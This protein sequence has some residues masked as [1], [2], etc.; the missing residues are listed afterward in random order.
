MASPISKQDMNIMTEAIQIAYTICYCAI[1]IVFTLLLLAAEIC[2]ADVI[3]HRVCY[4]RLPTMPGRTTDTKVSSTSTST[5][6]T[7]ASDPTNNSFEA[8][9]SP[10]SSTPTTLQTVLRFLTTL[11]GFILFIIPFLI[12]LMREPEQG[13]QKPDIYKIGRDFAFGMVPGSMVLVI[14]VLVEAVCLKAWRVIDAKKG[15]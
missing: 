1:N 6:S 11:N 8:E 15:L 2:L 14:C 5:S 7:N 12:A 4:G 13:K 3:L 9:T 10:T